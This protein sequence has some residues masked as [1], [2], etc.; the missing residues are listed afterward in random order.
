MQFLAFFCAT[1][2]PLLHVL[3]GEF[4]SLAPEHSINNRADEGVPI[5]VLMDKATGD[6]FCKVS[7]ENIGGY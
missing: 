2:F 7:S 3:D 1:G 4:D 5:N 6:F